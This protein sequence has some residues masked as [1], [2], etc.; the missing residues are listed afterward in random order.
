MTEE[1]KM[2]IEKEYKK[3]VGDFFSEEHL[4][5]FMKSLVLSYIDNA[6]KFFSEKGLKFDNPKDFID[7]IEGN[8]SNHFTVYLNSAIVN[9]ISNLEIK[10]IH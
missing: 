9:L 8:L 2:E 6:Q 4:I 1:Q 3:M 10:K 5:N 7:F